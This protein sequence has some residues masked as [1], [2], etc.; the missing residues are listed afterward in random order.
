MNGAFVDPG[1]A[2]PGMAVPAPVI[3]SPLNF[4]SVLGAFGMGFGQ[5]DHAR[6]EICLWNE[7]VQSVVDYI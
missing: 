2:F 1:I 6:F 3:W 5:A 4:A 7:Q